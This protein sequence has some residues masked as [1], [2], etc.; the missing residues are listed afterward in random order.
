M[1]FSCHAL[2]PQRRLRTTPGSAFGNLQLLTISTQG[3]CCD[4]CLS[5]LHLGKTSV[6]PLMGSQ[7]APTAGVVTAIMPSDDRSEEG[8][9]ISCNHRSL[10]FADTN[11]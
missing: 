9:P 7:K 3:F 11:E 4:T 6:V 10:A 8:M 2:K 5:F 1:T